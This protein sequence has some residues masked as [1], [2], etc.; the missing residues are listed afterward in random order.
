MACHAFKIFLPSRWTLQ[1]E[2]QARFSRRQ[3]ARVR[4]HPRRVLLGVV[5]S[6]GAQAGRPSRLLAAQDKNLNTGK[7]HVLH[8]TPTVL[9]RPPT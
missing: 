3:V 6:A 8:R 2:F 9:C 4:Q 1:T 5:Y 7:K